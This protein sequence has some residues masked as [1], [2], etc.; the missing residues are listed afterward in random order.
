MLIPVTT[1]DTWRLPLE[2]NLGRGIALASR[3]LIYR[4]RWLIT[5][6]KNDKLNAYLCGGAL[7]L[8]PRSWSTTPQ[9]PFRD[10]SQMLEILDGGK[11]ERVNP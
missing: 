3:S 11:L 4:R 9:L 8:K 5:G 1:V 10:Y 2:A 6:A 7:R